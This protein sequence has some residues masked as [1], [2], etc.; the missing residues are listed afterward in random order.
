MTMISYGFRQ[1]TNKTPRTRRH[2]FYSLDIAAKKSLFSHR[3][4]VWLQTT[5]TSV[6]GWFGVVSS[7]VTNTRNMINLSSFF[8]T[9]LHPP[10][11]HANASHFIL[12]EAS[13]LKELLFGAIDLACQIK[14]YD[15]PNY[16]Q[17]FITHIAKNRWQ[18]RNSFYEIC[19]LDKKRSAH[20]SSIGLFSL[21]ARPLFIS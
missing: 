12:N 15:W 19:D 4:W 3:Q 5:T 20:Q 21:L 16:Y 1:L 2:Y 10:K 8:S 13:F 11:R 18:C 6:F 17:Q 14:I 9:P 7:R